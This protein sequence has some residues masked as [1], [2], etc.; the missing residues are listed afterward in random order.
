MFV[1][2]GGSFVRR[3]FLLKDTNR[4]LLLLSEQIHISIRKKAKVCSNG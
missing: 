4:K 3:D 1:P 2:V